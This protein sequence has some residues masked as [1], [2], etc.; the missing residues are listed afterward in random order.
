MTIPVITVLPIAPARTDTPAVFNTRADAFLGALYSPF[1]TQMN[2]SITA[3]NTDISGVNA[4]AIAAA[5]SATAAAAS[6][7]SAAAAA[8]AALWVSGTSYAEGDAAISGIDYLTYRANTATSGTTDPSTS[9]DWVQINITATSTN[10]L[11]NKTLTAPVLTAPVL[12]TPASGVMTSVTGLPLTTGVTGTLPVANGGTGI[13]AAGTSGNVL[14]SDGTNWASTAPAGSAGLV[15]IQ[16]VTASNVANITLSGFSSTYDSY[17]IEVVNVYGG[18]SS[19]LRM[20][21]TVDG[22]EVTSGYH[23]SVES[24]AAGADTTDIAASENLAYLSVTNDVLGAASAR[25]MSTTMRIF[26]YTGYKTFISHGIGN[27]GGLTNAD[28][29]GG[30]E[31]STGTLNS[32]NFF[33]DSGNIYGKFRLYGIVKS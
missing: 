16:E 29:I 15:F 4:D 25:A 33:L 9:G 5:A 32:V 30:H 18:N 7:S 23:S 8:D 17:Q 3:I 11:T 1:S 27:Y 26:G 6:A 21:F 10:T 20:T 12:G 28:A 2:A 14:T 22:S 13:T 24:R 31:S 19:K